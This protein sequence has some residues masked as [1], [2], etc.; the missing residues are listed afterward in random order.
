MPFFRHHLLRAG[1]A[2]TLM[3]AT[4]PLTVTGQAGPEAAAAAPTSAAVMSTGDLLTAGQVRISAGGQ[5]QLEMQPNGDLTVRSQG[6]LV[7]RSGTAGHPGA[8]ARMQIDGNLVV[9]DAGG[10]ARWASRTFGHRG[11]A[12]TVGTD[13]LLS[14]RLAGAVVWTNQVYI[15][16]LTAGQVLKPGWRLTAP[17]RQVVTAMQ[18]DGDLVTAKNGVPVWRSNTKGHPGASATMQGDGNLVVRGPDGRALWNSRSWGYAGALAQMQ[19]D[20]Y[21]V[22]YS[23]VGAPVWWRDIG[24]GAALC[25]STPPSA[26]GTSVTRWHPVELC[27]LAVLRQSSASLSDVDLMIRWESSGDANAINLWDLNAKAGHPSKG[28]IQVIQPTFNRFR[29]LQLSADLFNPAANLYAGLNYAIYTYGSIHNIPGLVSLRN[30]G[31]YKG[32]VTTA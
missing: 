4:S 26:R 29:S 15:S 25:N 7:W 5:S 28:L 6:A 14:V 1:A 3:F 30:G 11:A 22:V 13:G 10:L 31:G 20:G 24:R 2:V 9:R 19:A 8:S 18:P 17:G 16:R 32:Y 12:L 23:A 27:V 21:F